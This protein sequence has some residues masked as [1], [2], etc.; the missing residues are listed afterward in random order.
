MYI[1]LEITH[2]QGKLDIESSVQPVKVQSWDQIL[3]SVYNDTKDILLFLQYFLSV[4]LPRE[5]KL[6]SALGEPR[7]S[8]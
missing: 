5:D 2:S 6:S 8:F 4:Q 7:V 3:L 1:Q